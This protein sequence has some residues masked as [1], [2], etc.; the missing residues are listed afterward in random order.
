[1]F[2]ATLRIAAILLIFQTIVFGQYPTAD[3]YIETYRNLAISE[4]KRTGIPASIKMGQ[5]LLESAA[6]TSTLATKA[7]NHFG[8]KC[9]SVW[10]G[11]SYG[12]RDDERMLLVFKKKSCFRKYN[13]AEESYIDHSEFIR[14][15]NGPYSELFNLNKTDYKAW[16]Y[17]LK[18]AGYATAGDY[19]EKLIGIIER[20][21]LY[22][23]DGLTAPDVMVTSSDIKIEKPPSK[24]LFSIKTRIIRIN[25]VKAIIAN[26]GE[27]PLSLSNITNESIDNILKYNDYLRFASQSLNQNDVVYLCKKKKSFW[28]KNKTHIVSKG[29]NMFQISQLYG[30]R[31]DKLYERN[32]L[33]PDK[34][35]AI[36]QIVYLRGK[37]PD[38]DPIL[39]S[40][41]KVIPN[42]KSS[43]NPALVNSNEK[44]EIISKKQELTSSSHNEV[45][46]PVSKD[47][48][49]IKKPIN[50]NEV[51]A[52]NLDFIIEPTDKIKQATPDKTE[53]YNFTP[54]TTRN[55]PNT[56][57]TEAISSEQVQR[58][59]ST[60]DITQ[61]T[62]NNNFKP[63]IT[64]TKSSTQ[65]M[66]PSTQKDKI[67]SNN[68]LYH[69]VTNGDTLYN[70]SKRYST[71]VEKLKSI[72]QLPDNNIHLGQKL[73]VK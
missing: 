66:T 53:R 52:E 55:K 61:T 49:E 67:I 35:P 30:V 10:N 28:G 9:G 58:K 46:R 41:D 4:M 26:A 40:N 71:T 22:Q 3:Q 1:M 65:I 54:A 47:D 13:N 43:N 45:Q 19:P 64:N 8:I 42:E 16:A 11:D 25:Q 62:E 7:N 12:R 38:N 44:P 37:R 57:N 34:E 39:I 18:K 24:P 60:D 23:L 59:T 51:S 72:N 27:T 36:G 63:A 56:I 73:K 14:R 69:T 21:H 6:G 70:I 32:H 2:K 17:G 29:E 31:I 15:P 68:T 5:A 50:N 48:N 33:N 20:Y